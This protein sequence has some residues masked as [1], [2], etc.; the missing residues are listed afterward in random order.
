M[1]FASLQLLEDEPVSW[2][3]TL[4]FLR[5]STRKVFV[6][7]LLFLIFSR[8]NKGE[9]H[10]GQTLSTGWP[11]SMETLEAFVQHDSWQSHLPLASASQL[12]AVSQSLRDATSKNRHQPELNMPSA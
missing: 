12:S 1:A 4:C 9:A 8:K 11:V 10:P 5:A 6:F 2:Q 3:K 7:E